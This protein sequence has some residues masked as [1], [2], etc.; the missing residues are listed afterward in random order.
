MNSF[1]SIEKVPQDEA[2]LLK[3]LYFV[4]SDFGRGLTNMGSLV[5]KNIEIV[6]I[7]N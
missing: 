7:Q 6:S 3:L 2:N 1:G 4:L 5:E